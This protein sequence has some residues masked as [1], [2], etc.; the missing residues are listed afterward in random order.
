M[1][2]IHDTQPPTDIP[3]EGMQVDTSETDLNGSNVLE[4][5]INEC[6]CFEKVCDFKLNKTKSKTLL[7][8][9]GVPSES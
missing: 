7:V 1:A 2:D 8:V 4:M 6:D 9:Y 3:V 5:N